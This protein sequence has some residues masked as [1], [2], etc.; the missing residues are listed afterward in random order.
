[1]KRLI[2]IFVSSAIGL[3]PMPTIVWAEDVSFQNMSL[4]ETGKAIVQEYSNLLDRAYENKPLESEDP[5]FSFS[6]PSFVKEQ[7]ATIHE[8]LSLTGLTLESSAVAPSDVVTTIT[9]QKIIID[10]VI[11][12]T[13]SFISPRLDGTYKEKCSWSE[14][15]KLVFNI[16]TLSTR[17]SSAP[18]KTVAIVSDSSSTEFNSNSPLKANAPTLYDGL[19]S[20]TVRE[21][22]QSAPSKEFNQPRAGA[23]PAINT[24]P[25]A[26]YALKWTAPPYNGD[27]KSDYN[28]VY[29][30]FGAMHNC[31]NFVSQAA[32]AGGLPIKEVNGDKTDLRNWSPNLQWGA[33]SHT[34][35]LASANYTYMKTNA[36]DTSSDIWMDQGSLIYADWQ[37]D[38]S[39][40]HALIV[41]SAAR[42]VL[43]NGKIAFDTHISQKS[44]NRSNV[45]LGLYLTIALRDNPHVRWYP[46]KLRWIPL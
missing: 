19:S 39:I 25:M 3:L 12:T 18:Q 38:G 4:Q 28:S 14:P 27:E 42:N 8:G 2:A 30:Y 40:D 16:D 13:I 34:W 31:A 7:A 33:V 41:T 11:H 9:Q 23:R 1:M 17:N 20:Q 24:V 43:P 45:P 37:N 35:S 6:N 5:L 10:A 22:I 26:N 15:H 44:R 21:Q 36:Y 32:R 46:L 29:P